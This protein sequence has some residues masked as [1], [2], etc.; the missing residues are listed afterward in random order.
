MTPE[1]KVKQIITRRIDQRFGRDTYR[2]MPMG[3]GR[4]TSG[5]PDFVYCIRGL[6]VGIEAK[7]PGGKPTALQSRALER[8]IRAGGM[9]RVVDSERS[10]LAFL[11]LVEDRINRN[12]G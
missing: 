3:T 11:D 4:G 5:Q 8:I 9:A 12:V 10:L 1:G 7:A 2:I 6:F